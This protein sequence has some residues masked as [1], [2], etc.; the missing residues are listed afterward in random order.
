MTMDWRLLMSPSRLTVSQ[1][2]AVALVAPQAFE[3]VRG[4]F[5][6]DGDRVIYSA[7]FRR[8]QDKTQVQPFPVTDY[9][10]TR[11]THSLEVAS[12]G[13]S[14]GTYIGRNVL[15]RHGRLRCGAFEPS[16]EDFG[17]AVAAAS[18]AHDIGNPPFG[19]AGEDAIRHWFR[20]E[21]S[22]LLDAKL[23]DAAICDL[24]NFEGNAQGFRILTRLQV[25]RER[26]GLRLSA[27]T[28]G[29]FSKYPCASTAMGAAAARRK[30]GF[31][32]T[33]RDCFAAVAAELGLTAHGGD[34]WARHP[35]AYLVEAAD[36]I[37]YSI[38][39]LEDGVKAGKIK[40]AE[41]ES[42]LAAI[43]GDTLVHYDDIV[44]DMDRIGY[45]RAQAIGVLTD[46]A[47]QVFL[48]NEASILG[49]DFED[50]LIDH[51]A[52]RYRVREV[53]DLCSE[54][55]F[56]DPAKLEAELGGF[57]VVRGLLDLFG[58]AVAE[59]QACGGDTDRLTPRH[60]RLIR[61][62]PGGDGAGQSPAAQWLR[63]TDYISGMTDRF[64]LSQFHRLSGHSIG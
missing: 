43:A 19:H 46:D 50:A 21:G 58:S 48:D 1:T 39:D 57:E 16:Q 45:L 2:G 18:L 10:R 30:F 25:W 61:L 47:S 63:L 24:K 17:A 35:L 51:V 41:A 12:V 5:H 13:R 60:R 31:F 3:A 54:R 15:A 44:E 8:L 52:N 11:L 64:A 7:A 6:K 36:D 49:G 37:C 38:V 62:L 20:S 59:F 26:G 55:L 4:P 32:Q 40:F 33:E 28:L 9:L 23:G 14:L 42:L 53:A 22:H 29:A 27:A 56:H 34:A